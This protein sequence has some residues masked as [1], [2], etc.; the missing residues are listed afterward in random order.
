MYTSFSSDKNLE[1]F[2][3]FSAMDLAQKIGSPIGNPTISKF[4]VGSLTSSVKPPRSDSHLHVL[5]ARLSGG[6]RVCIQRDQNVHCVL[7]CIS[8][9]TTKWHVARVPPVQKCIYSGAHC[10]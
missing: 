2:A 6:P 1:A 4:S 7:Q 3:L 10:K 9:W 8:Y 5:I